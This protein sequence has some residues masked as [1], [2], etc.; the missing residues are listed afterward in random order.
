M[1]DA[2]RNFVHG[3]MSTLL[4]GLGVPFEKRA[5]GEDEEPVVEKP[6][7]Q[8]SAE[9][10]RR[11]LYRAEYKRVLGDKYDEA[12]ADADADT[13]MAKAQRLRFDTL[14]DAERLAGPAV[15]DDGTN[16]PILAHRAVNWA[17]WRSPY[18][19]IAPGSGLS[20]GVPVVLS[21]GRPGFYSDVNLLVPDTLME[22]PGKVVLNPA[23]GRNLGNVWLHE[24]AHVATPSALIADELVG[25][26]F[27]GAGGDAARSALFGGSGYASGQSEALVAILAEKARMHALGLLDQD[28]HPGMRW[29]SEQV[30][31]PSLPEFLDSHRE[32]I[33]ALSDKPGPGGSVSPRDARQAE[34][35]AEWTAANT[36]PF[37]TFDDDLNVKSLRAI[38]TDLHR[39]A[40]SLDAT[41][42]D[43]KRYADFVDFVDYLFQ[44]A[45]TGSVDR[46]SGLA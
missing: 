39:R 38:A 40:T 20:D 18:V 12:Q 34:L 14:R 3:Y 6:L 43:R 31:K 27:W 29:V 41:Y 36:T 25:T 2:T 19:K 5:E 17:G 23:Y 42:A 45:D 15:F 13:D 33:D 9:Q 4:A 35:E 1:P 11:N 21:N 10:A 30:A 44:R 22:E 26:S 7:G 24:G 28:D 16:Y 8:I 32:E 46:Y 37:D